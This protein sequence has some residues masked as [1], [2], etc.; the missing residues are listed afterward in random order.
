MQGIFLGVDPGTTGS[1]CILSY[2]DDYECP[3]T[4]INF[5][6]YKELISPDG[7]DIWR[8]LQSGDITFAVLERVWAFSGQGVKSTWTFGQSVGFVKGFLHAHNVPHTEVLPKEWQVVLK[9]HD[10]IDGKERSRIAALAWV[11]ENLAGDERDH[12]EKELSRKMDHNRADALFLAL[13]AL[14][15][16]ERFI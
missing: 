5:L 13:W 16:H 9:D 15:N 4:S 11:E 3:Y 12:V 14:Q 8:K 1:L 6:S 2:S 10:N 7:P